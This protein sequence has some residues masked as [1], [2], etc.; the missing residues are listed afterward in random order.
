MKKLL[1]FLGLLALPVFA[2]SPTITQSA[3]YPWRLQCDFTYT[4]GTI[5][6][7]PI[8]QFYQTDLTSNGVL[9]TH[10]TSTPSALTVD[11]V[12]KASSTVTVNGTTYTY[13]QAI[14]IVTALLAQERVAQLAAQ[15]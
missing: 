10:A 15:H 11:L 12:A 2:Q 13:A 8:T 5:S 4:S 14:Q 9:L 7:A 1:C 3:E 6:A